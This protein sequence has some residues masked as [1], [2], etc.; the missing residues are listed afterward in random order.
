MKFAPRAA[1]ALTSF[2]NSSLA[3]FREKIVAGSDEERENLL[4]KLDCGAGAPAEV[5][6]SGFVLA[7][8]RA[9]RG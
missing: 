6:C 1:P 2:A 8:A 5:C 4:R 3:P 7:V 9:N